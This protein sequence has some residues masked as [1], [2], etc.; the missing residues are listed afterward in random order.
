V[1]TDLDEVINIGG[2]GTP[3]VAVVAGSGK[4]TSFSGALSYEQV[5]GLV[6]QARL[7]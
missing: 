5:K 2:R 3:F 6:E 7:R 1:Q 4:V